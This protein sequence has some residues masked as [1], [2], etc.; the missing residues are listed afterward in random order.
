MHHSSQVVTDLVEGKG[1][2]FSDAGDFALKGYER[3]VH[4]FDLAWEVE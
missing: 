2:L 4:L 3:A 1:Y